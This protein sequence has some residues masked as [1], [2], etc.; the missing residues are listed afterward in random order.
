MLITGIFLTLTGKTF[1]IS[2]RVICAA[3][4]IRISVDPSGS[5]LWNRDVGVRVFGVVHSTSTM[6]ER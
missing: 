6:Q 1:G 5:E 3:V 2:A 4:F